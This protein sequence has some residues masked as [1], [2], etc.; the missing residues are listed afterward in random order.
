MIEQ[1]VKDWFPKQLFAKDLVGAQRSIRLAP[2]VH[3]GRR[4]V[5]H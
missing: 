5:R 4:Q 3:Q 2:V 1:N